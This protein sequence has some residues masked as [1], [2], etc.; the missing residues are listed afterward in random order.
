M[1]PRSM[2]ILCQGYTDAKEIFEYI[3]YRKM[4]INDAFC[5]N[6]KCLEYKFEMATIREF[7][8]VMRKKVRDTGDENPSFTMAEIR[9]IMC[10]VD[11]KVLSMKKY[12]CYGWKQF[13]NRRLGDV[14]PSSLFS[15][16]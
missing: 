3:E 1:E 6:T 16:L 7:E 10:E 9:S 8:K 14:N 12:Q 11:E 5:S 2:E 13:Q 15:L 4:I